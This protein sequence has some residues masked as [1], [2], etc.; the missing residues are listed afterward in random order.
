MKKLGLILLL[1][2]LVFALAG[3]ANGSQAP[4]TNGTST[5]PGADL[6]EEGICTI[7]LQG[8]PCYDSPTSLF[9]CQKRAGQKWCNKN[10]EC[11]KL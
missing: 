4:A 7:C 9:Y 6:Y 3:C 1:G 10:N 5:A 8:A 11:Q 2:S